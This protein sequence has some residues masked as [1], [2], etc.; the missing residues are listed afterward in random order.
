[1]TLRNNAVN[2]NRAPNSSRSRIGVKNMVNIP[3]DLAENIDSAGTD[4]V[5][6]VN[7]IT[8][9]QTESL[10]FAKVLPIAENEQ[11]SSVKIRIHYVITNVTT[12]AEDEVVVFDLATIAVGD[13]QNLAEGTATATATTT[14][15]YDGT[16]EQNDKKASEWVT[17]YHNQDEDGETFTYADLLRINLE[18]DATSDYAQEIGIQS[19][20]IA[21]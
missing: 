19:I 18:F 6:N 2:T 4:T 17:V 15:T 14:I 16:E 7:L 9:A 20:D 1:M 10:E 5:G 3:I 8:L 12:P 13:G 11:V 21:W